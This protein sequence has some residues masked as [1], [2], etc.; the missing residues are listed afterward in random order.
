MSRTELTV[1]Q[2]IL[3]A[4]G[5]QPALTSRKTCAAT[6]KGRL[7]GGRRQNCLPHYQCRWHS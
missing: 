6:R 3:A 7:K 4:A 2:P 1:G 5:F